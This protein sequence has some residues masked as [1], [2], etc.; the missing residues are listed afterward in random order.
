MTFYIGDN[1]TNLLFEGWN[2]SSTGDLMKMCAV[3]F[4]LAIVMEALKVF[5]AFLQM[6]ADLNPLT[7]AK[8]EHNVNERSQL[9]R[10]LIIP[11]SVDHIKRRKI[12]Y[13]IAVTLVNVLTLLMGYLAMLAIM[14]YNAAIAISI[15]LGSAIGYFIFSAIQRAFIDF[16]PE[17]E[18]E[19]TQKLSNTG[20]SSLKP[21]EI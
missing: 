14:S 17:R 20:Y 19:R 4:T 15:V 11:P 16:F 5:R 2:S 8:T 1:V 3:F 13:H 18:A 10:P 12:Y 9:L 21:K 7:Y 6:R